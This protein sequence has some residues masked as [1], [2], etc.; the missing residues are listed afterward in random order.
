M[1]R[2]TS[3]LLVIILIC[4]T[5]L[6]VGCEPVG[7]TIT[8]TFVYQTGAEN[9]T[10]QV[11]SGKTVKYPT[12]PTSEYGTFNAWCT[13]P[14]GEHPWD[15]KTPITEPITLY[16]SWTRNNNMGPQITFNFNYEEASPKTVKIKNYIGF[17]LVQPEIPERECFVFTGWYTTKDCDPS[18]RWD[19]LKVVENKAVTL[20]AGWELESDHKHA[21]EVGGENVSSVSTTVAPTCV[22]GGYDE[23]IC[24]CGETNRTNEQSALG[25]QFDMDPNDFFR[26]VLCSNADTTGCTQVKRLESENNYE[27][28]FVYTFNDAKATE[29]DEL[30]DRM[31]ATL[32][33]AAK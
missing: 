5:V 26:F 28:V 8:V 20:F 24:A 23:E 10:A 14:A 13:D 1:K 6:A 9:T 2:F 11:V 30:Y 21:W 27:D 29:I 7:D 18:Q 3:L 15:Q 32:N 25:H 12:T 4:T 19:E 31:I 17:T 22:K 33:N 16:A